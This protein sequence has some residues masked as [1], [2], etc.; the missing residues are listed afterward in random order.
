VAIAASV[1]R[2][3]DIAHVLDDVARQL[4]RATAE[5]PSGYI[6]MPMTFP[7]GAPIIVHVR[8]DD[9]DYIVT[10]QGK[11][12]YEAEMMGAGSAFL[13]IAR[14]VA[15]ATGVEFDGDQMFATR[16]PRDWLPNAVMFVAN[17]SRSA[18]EIAAERLTANVEETLRDRLKVALRDVFRDR[19][20]FDVTVPGVST[21]GRTFAA[22]VRRDGRTALFDVVMPSPVSVSFAIVKFQD[23]AQLEAGPSR[24][25]LLGGAV[26]AGDQTLLSQWATV[27]PFN[28]NREFLRTAA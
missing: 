1:E 6:A 22:L 21:K 5:G 10:D 4:I 18:V 14:Q 26:D 17:A 7:G 9:E 16:V 13:R 20:S 19:A 15:A 3:S 23:V 12:H 8:R 28:D 2:N 11:G 27:T 24:V 25:A